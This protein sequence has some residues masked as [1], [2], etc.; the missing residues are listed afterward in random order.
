[1]DDAGIGRAVLLGWYWETQESCAA[2]NRFYAA[3]V[4]SHPDRLAAFAAVNPAGGAGRALAEARRAVGEGFAGFGE[5]FPAAQGF[6]STDPG[7][8][9][10][11][12]LAG[13]LR[14]PVNLHATDPAGRPYPGM[15]PTPDADF[16]RIAR[17]NPGTRFILAHWGGMLPVRSAEALALPNLFYDTAASPLTYD[18]G[19]WARF[20]ATVGADRVLFGSDYP[21]TLYPGRETGASWRNLLAEVGGANLGAGPLSSILGGNALRVV[22]L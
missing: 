6:P 2:Q 12:A 22:K 5:L 20:V 3:C 19:V 15:L 8:A 18:P 21:L 17:E 13:E 16:L 9:G 10:I 11:L 4:R 14:M 1:M 7:F